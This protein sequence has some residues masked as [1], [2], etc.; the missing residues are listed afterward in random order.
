MNE[1]YLGELK[2]KYVSDGTR[3]ITEHSNIQPFLEHNFKFR[4]A[5]CKLKVKYKWWFGI[6][7]RALLP[8]QKQIRNINA[9]AIL[10]MHKM[11]TRC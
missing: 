8:F 9:K 10:R 4:K 2:L 3:S 1:H 11:Q 6:I 5:Y 7:V